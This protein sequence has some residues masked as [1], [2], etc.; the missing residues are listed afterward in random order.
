[1]MENRVY[2]IHK[3]INQSMEFRGLKA[4]YVTL[5]AVGTIVLLLLFAL[6]Q[7]LLVPLWI[8]LGMNGLFGLYLYHKVYQ[9]NHR[10]REFG[11]LKAL[12]ARRIPKSIRLRSRKVFINYG[13]P[14]RKIQVP[15]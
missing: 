11:L 13:A 10:Y 15:T 8:C 12:A 2:R 1:M 3:K 7:F 5:L 4:L 14:G 9:M 6:L